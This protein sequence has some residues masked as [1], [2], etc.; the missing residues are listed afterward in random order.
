MEFFTNIYNLIVGITSELYQ[1]FFISSIVYV[2]YFLG[3]LGIKL[4]A[5]FK[6]QQD[7]KFVISEVGMRVLWASIAIILTYLI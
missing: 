2:L 7:T 4:F 5:R 6:L 1:L 3:N